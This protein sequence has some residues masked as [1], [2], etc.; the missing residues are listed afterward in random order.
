MRDETM[1]GMEQGREPVPGTG[2]KTKTCPRC[3][4]GLFED[5]DV[6]YGCLYDFTRDAGRRSENPEFPPDLFEEDGERADA[7]CGGTLTAQ[8][9]EAMREHFGDGPATAGEPPACAHMG[10]PDGTAPLRL[11]TARRRIALRVDVA[12]ASA[13]VPVGRDGVTVGRDE[14]CDVVLRS[15]AVSRRHLRVSPAVGGAYLADLGAT[16]PTL[17]AGVPLEGEE[18]VPVGTEVDVCGTSLTVMAL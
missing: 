17:V 14:S 8:D 16:N 9:E 6:C 2:F 7:A 12:G 4:A 5:M 11:R 13:T 10:D 15:R 3:G 1:T 18:E